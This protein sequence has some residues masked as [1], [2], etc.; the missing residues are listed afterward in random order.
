M[1]INSFFPHYAKKIANKNNCKFIQ[2]STDYVFDG[3]KEKQTPYKTSEKRAPLGIYG[4]SKACAE[5]A[6]EEIFQ[7][8]FQEYIFLKF[9]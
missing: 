7:D 3:K 6:I 5:E 2:I 4:L 9:Y 1:K 8:S